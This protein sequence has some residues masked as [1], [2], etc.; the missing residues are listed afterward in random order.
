MIQQNYANHSRYVKGYHL[1]LSALLLFGTIASLIN[2]WLQY[3]AHD[4]FFSALLI[5]VLFVSGLFIFLFMRQFPM[6]AQDRAIRAEESLR[7]FILTRKP[8]DSKISMRQ[9]I[10]L[11]FAPDDEFVTLVD[12]AINESLSPDEIKRAIKN[13]RA[14]NFRM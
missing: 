13:W 2:A 6:K 9:I 12:K 11:R 4:N 1:I 7:Y 5:T 14:D 10:A 8:L 3:R